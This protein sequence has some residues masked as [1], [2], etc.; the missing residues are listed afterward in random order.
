MTEL[1]DLDAVALRRLIGAKEIS[2]RELLASCLARI[3]AV[4]PTVNAIVAMDIEGAEA[5]AAEAERAVLRGDALGALHG[6]PVGIKDLTETKGLRTTFGSLLFEHHV[7]ARDARMVAAIRAA[8]GIVLAK[9]NTPEFG[10]G[11]NTRNGVYGATT[12]PFNA[13]LTPAGSSGGSAA[14]LATGMLPLATGSDH[15][16]SLRT[17]AGFCGVVGMRPTAGLV[18]NERRLLA[19]SA[20]AVDGPMGRAV[21]D[22]ALLLS[23]I[24]ANDPLDPW[25]APVDAAALATPPEVDL[26]SLR[27][28]VSQDLGFAPMDDDIRRVFHARCGLFADLFRSCVERDPDLGDAARVVAVTRA[29]SVLADYE[30]V[31]K[32]REDRLQYPVRAN[33]EQAMTFTLADRAWAQVEQAKLYRR[34]EALFTEI[35]LLICPTASVS[36]FPHAAWAPET[37]GGE[38]M[39]SYYHWIMITYGITLTGHPVVVIPCGVDEKGL[40]FGIQLVGPKR[41]DR[42]LLGVAAAMERIFQTRPALKRPVPTRAG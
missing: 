4:N 21:G 14:A 29:E 36:P 7:P 11:A 35:D 38:T 19:F 23:A 40:P 3:A 31:Y 39:T 26:S 5:A 17:P 22:A 16:G 34:F 20:L 8:G 1:C 13:E 15:G 41:G 27:V 10:A 6:L 28:A 33:I 24:A 30:T 32:G 2:P 18:P 42:F 9:T 25:S 37:V 12:N